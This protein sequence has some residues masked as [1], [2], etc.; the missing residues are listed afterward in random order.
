LDRY[1]SSFSFSTSSSSPKASFDAWLYLDTRTES[2]SFSSPYYDDE[3]FNKG[4]GPSGGGSVWHP[5]SAEG[6]SRMD[7]AGLPSWLGSLW[8]SRS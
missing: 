5:Q 1:S 8:Q 3:Y 6:T 4:A 2:S 7:G